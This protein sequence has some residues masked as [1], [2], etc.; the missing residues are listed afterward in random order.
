MPPALAE[1]Q[2]RLAGFP[3]AELTH[4]FGPLPDV[5]KVGGKVFAMLVDAPE[6]TRLTLKCDPF[7]AEILRQ[8][9]PAVRP[10]Y[11]T[12]KRHWNTVHL[13]QPLPQDVLRNM[14]EASYEL[15]RGSLTKRAQAALSRPG[16]GAT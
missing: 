12:D 10:G 7:L 2:A 6:G 15:V 13:D 14:I 11:H 9:H 5:Y 16:E 3:G 1:L 8:A 4:P